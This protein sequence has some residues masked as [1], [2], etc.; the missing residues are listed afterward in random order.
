MGWVLLSLLAAVAFTAYTLV[1]KRTLDRHV[2]SVF[3]FALIAALLQGS[4]SVLILIVSPPDWWST[5]VLIMAAAGVLMAAA[6]LLQGY[7]IRREADVARVVPVLDAYPLIVLI[8]AMTVLG[9]TLTPLKAGAALLV[10]SGAVV[11]SWHQA[12]PGSRIKVNRSLVAMG[13]AA[14]VLGAI[15]ILAKAGAGQVT[16]LQMYAVMWVFALPVLLLAARSAGKL[17]AVRDVLTRPQAMG[18]ITLAQV[19]LMIAFITSMWAITLGPVSLSTA[20]MSTRP[21]LLLLWAVAAGTSLRGATGDGQ[22][23]SGLRARWAAAA[24][25]TVGVG[26]MAI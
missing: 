11:A 5:G 25:V 4:L 26:A 21:V 9:E 10:I 12:L 23:A 19:P 3:E 22:P 15:S 17:S 18:W 16:P 13:T 8:L 6:Q 2:G 14:L 20:I 7:V 1:Q 24:L